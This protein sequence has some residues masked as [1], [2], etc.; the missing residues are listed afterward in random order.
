MP[1]D[2]PSL[3]VLTHAVFTMRQELMGR[4]TQGM[5]K[6]RHARVPHSS[7]CC[8]PNLWASCLHDPIRYRKSATGN[9][10]PT[11]RAP[12]FYPY[13]EP[14]D[15]HTQLSRHFENHGPSEFVMPSLSV[16]IKD[17]PEVANTQ[18]EPADKPTNYL[19]Q[20]HLPKAWYLAC[21]VIDHLEPK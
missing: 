6:Q 11:V 17:R 9:P 12:K 20:E 4:I 19:P 8:V 3:E 16:L 21:L 1:N 7:R 14:A 13:R 5:V 15:G 10:A 2:T 18:E